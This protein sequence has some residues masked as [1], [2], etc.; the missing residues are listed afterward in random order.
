MNEAKSVYVNY[1]YYVQYLEV[2]STDRFC[3]GLLG[4]RYC[5]YEQGKMI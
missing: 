3:I 5:I 4:V 2:R 1:V